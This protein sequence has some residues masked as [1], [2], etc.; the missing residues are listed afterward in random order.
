[1]ITPNGVDPI[2]ELVQFAHE[3]RR[4]MDRRI[5][6]AEPSVRRSQILQQVARILTSVDL[7]KTG[8]IY[9]LKGSD[10]VIAEAVGRRM[11]SNPEF[12][13][14]ATALAYFTSDLVD[15]ALEH[16]APATPGDAGD[17]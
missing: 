4:E 2:M 10:R 7:Y 3:N 5:V 8:E 13:A 16:T 12:C 17:R 11:K 1:M 9:D 14:L 15:A 6:S